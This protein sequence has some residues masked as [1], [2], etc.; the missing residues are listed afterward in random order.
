MPSETAA[1]PSFVAAAFIYAARG[2][3]GCLAP[4]AS[5]R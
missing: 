3:R 4:P 2:M 1:V 5:S